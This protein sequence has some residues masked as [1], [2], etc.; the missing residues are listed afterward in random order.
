MALTVCGKQVET[1][2]G[3]PSDN[4]LVLIFGANTDTG[5]EF[6]TWAQ[7]KTCLLISSGGASLRLVV[8]E[9]G[10]PVAEDSTFQRNELIGLDPV[11]NPARISIKIDGQWLDSWGGNKSFDYNSSTGEIDLG[12]NEWND[13]SSVE[14]PLTKT[15]N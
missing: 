7:I 3:C 1:T 13:G 11:N 8:G 14:I 2:S 4:A 5:L 9:S 10:A 15:L 12:S 6:K